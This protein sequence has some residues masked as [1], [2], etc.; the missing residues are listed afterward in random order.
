[1]EDMD[2]CAE[3]R[4][5]MVNIDKDSCPLMNVDSDRD[6]S[7]LMNVDRDGSPLMIADGSCEVAAT[8]TQA[9][10]VPPGTNSQTHTDGNLLNRKRKDISSGYGSRL[11]CEKKIKHS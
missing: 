10:S 5:T 7:P 8:E 11:H 1:M 4:A 9:V 3:W 2:Y 6:G